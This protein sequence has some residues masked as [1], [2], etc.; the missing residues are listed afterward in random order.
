M[1]AFFI[2]NEST[3]DTLETTDNLDD[4]V[5]FAKEAAKKGLAGDPVSILNS[6]GK[7]VGQ[8]VLTPDG[9]V[10]ELRIASE[11]KPFDAKRL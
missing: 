10:K 7:S 2:V 3:E 9:T 4:A 11:A 5:R 8:F 1:S 6:D